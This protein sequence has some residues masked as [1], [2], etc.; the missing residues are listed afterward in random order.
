MQRATYTRNDV[1]RRLAAAPQQR[2]LVASE[3]VQLLCHTQRALGYACERAEHV[4]AD[5]MTEAVVRILEVVEV[6]QRKTE[7][8]SLPE[9]RVEPLVEGATVRQAGERIAA[10]LC[11][12][13]EE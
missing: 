11:A 5:G 6:E 1:H 8:R 12:G 9:E 4:V 13:E 7:G 3:A 10:R 2:E